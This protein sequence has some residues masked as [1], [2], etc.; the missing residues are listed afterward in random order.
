VVALESGGRMSRQ[1]KVTA[2]L[3]LLRGE[4]LETVSRALGVTTATLTAYSIWDRR[5]LRILR[6]QFALSAPACWR[7]ARLASGASA[8]IAA[9]IAAAFLAIH[10][11]ITDQPLTPAMA[12]AFLNSCHFS[13]ARF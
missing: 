8:I 3:R 6:D 5:P 10:T 1:R 4:D 11:K 7:W 12:F 9:A 2:V 13:P